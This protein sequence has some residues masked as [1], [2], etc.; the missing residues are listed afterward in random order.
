MFLA[1]TYGGASKRL[2]GSP[3]ARED[4]SVELGAETNR[5]AQGHFLAPINWREASASPAPP[6]RKSR[7]STRSISTSAMRRVSGANARGPPRRLHR[8]MAI[9]PGQ[10]AIINEVFTPTAEAV[11]RAEA[12][13]A[14]FADNPGAGTVGIGGVMYDRP[15]LERA[16]QLLARAKETSK[17]IIKPRVSRP[18]APHGVERRRKRPARS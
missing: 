6:R 12:V 7:R 14:A 2:K 15:H 13:I 16:R 1:G 8:K 9:H 17:A 10:V 4:L 11:K 5:D 18:S 3:G